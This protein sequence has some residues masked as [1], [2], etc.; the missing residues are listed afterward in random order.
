VKGKGV[1]RGG[2]KK[3]KRRREKGDQQLSIY[4]HRPM[5]KHRDYK[6]EGKKGEGG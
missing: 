3:G 2:K 4:S 5:Y 6:S 1:K